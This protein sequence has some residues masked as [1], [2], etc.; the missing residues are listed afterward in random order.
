VASHG[1]GNVA[2]SSVVCTMILLLVQ[3]FQGP[4]IIMTIYAVEESPD[5]R[6]QS[7]ALG[8]TIVTVLIALL[9]SKNMGLE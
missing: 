8:A 6:S 5:S 9:R 4:R 7:I 1:V 2:R 3:D